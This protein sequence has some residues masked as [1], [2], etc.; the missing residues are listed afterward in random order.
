MTVRRWA[1]ATWLGWIAGVPLI[2]LFALVGEGLGIGGAQA[3]VGAGMG[4]GVGMLQSRALR[5]ILDRPKW[6]AWSCAIG[7]TLPF[8]VFDLLRVAGHKSS[9]SVQLAVASGGVAAGLWQAYLL[10]SRVRQAGWWIMISAFGWTLAALAAASADTITR[11]HAVR[12]VGGAL[13]YLG[14]VGIGGLI[15]GA[16]TGVGLVRLLRSSPWSPTS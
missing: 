4:T 6:W 16:S 14:I 13:L 15:L 1:R 11:G 9:Y 8:L 5:N 3:L 2:A 7:L 10:R 12:G